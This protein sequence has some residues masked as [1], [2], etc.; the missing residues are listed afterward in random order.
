ME[1]VVPW[2]QP[3][4]VWFI[5]GL[6]LLLIEFANPGV[7]V[8][9]FGF[10]AWIVALLSLFFNLSLNTQLIIFLITSLI[11]LAF[12]RRSFTKLFRDRLMQDK[13]ELL[14][15]DEYVGK[16]A[17]VIKTITPEVNGRV[18]FHGSTWDAEADEK[19]K[20][21]TPVV[22]TGMHNITLSVKKVESGKA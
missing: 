20:E 2:L 4:L 10:G 16:R 8:I 18:E 13:P 7:V 17:V 15:E 19:I 5:I 12:L 22:I 11:M 3:A 6:V 21:G 9:F 14:T 1:T